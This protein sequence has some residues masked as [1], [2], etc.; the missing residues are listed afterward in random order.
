MTTLK[1]A[2]LYLKVETCEFHRQEVKYLGLIV[3]VNSIRMDTEKVTAVKEWEAPGKF[4]EV[5]AF[6]GFV[7][8]YR[9]FIVNYSR[10]VQPLTKL[11]KM[12]VPF[13]WGPD[14]K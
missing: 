10:V 9:R 14:Q 2:G 1:E 8:F 4:K 13:H 5:Q 3:G 6:L 11:M 7:N 12:L